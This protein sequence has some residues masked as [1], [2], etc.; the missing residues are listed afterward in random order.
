MPEAVIREITGHSMR[1]MFKRCNTIDVDEKRRV[2]V[3]NDSQNGPRAGKDDLV[4]PS[5]RKG[6]R[7]EVVPNKIRTR[8]RVLFHWV[9]GEIRPFSMVNVLTAKAHNAGLC[10]VMSTVAPF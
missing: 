2:P 9:P 1:V 8:Q 10:V 3:Y 7:N 6:T 4:F 5:S